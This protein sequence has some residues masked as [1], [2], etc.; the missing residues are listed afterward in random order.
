M[1]IKH[2]QNSTYS[3]DWFL[4]GIKWK[5]MGNFK[6]QFSFATTMVKFTAVKILM[7]GRDWWNERQET[8]RKPMLKLLFT[9]DNAYWLASL[10]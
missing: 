10:K 9:P 6:L 3:Q 1:S 2:P 8:V 5:V 4:W 7:D